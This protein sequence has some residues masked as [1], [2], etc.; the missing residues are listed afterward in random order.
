MEHSPEMNLIIA[1]Q[2]DRI[3]EFVYW[4]EDN[5]EEKTSDIIE[6]ANNICTQMML[7]SD[8]WRSYEGKQS[9]SRICD[10]VTDALDKSW[11]YTPGANDEV[12]NRGTEICKLIV[13]FRRLFSDDLVCS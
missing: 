8:L 4:L 7:I 6:C 11:N 12:V 13:R 9:L 2:K 3:L 10:M 5:P 1:K